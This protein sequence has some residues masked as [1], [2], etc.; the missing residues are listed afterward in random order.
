MQGWIILERGKSLEAG[1]LRDEHDDDGSGL[2]FFEKKS[3]KQFLLDYIEQEELYDV[4]EIKIE[5]KR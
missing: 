3:A 4:V 2:V 5:V 1:W